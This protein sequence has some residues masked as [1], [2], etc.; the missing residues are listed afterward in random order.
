MWLNQSELGPLVK[1]EGMFRFPVAVL[2]SLTVTQST[3]YVG[4]GQMGFGKRAQRA[5]I[6]TCPA[7][8][9]LP[10]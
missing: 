2:V 1:A 4:G 10:K 5:Q 7:R 6:C 8:Q 3:G 9:V